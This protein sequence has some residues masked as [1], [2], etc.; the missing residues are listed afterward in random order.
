M[1][2]R[3]HLADRVHRL[4]VLA[5]IHAAR[6]VVQDSQL[7][8]I[9]HEFLGA[10]HQPAFQ[11]SAGM[12]HEVHAR[13]KPHV[14]AVG[15]F[16]RRLCIRQLRPAEGAGAAERQPQPPGKLARAIG[17]HARFGRAEG[18]RAGIH[19]DARHEGTKDHRAPARTSWL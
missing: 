8:G 6:H 13:Q 18:G 3:A 16:V 4:T 1:A 9:H 2:A 14:Q 17:D 5:Y 15:A 10:G 7:I 19:V 11:P 12:Q